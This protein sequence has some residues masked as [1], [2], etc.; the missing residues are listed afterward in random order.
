ML[1]VIDNYS[2]FPE[3]EI[4]RSTAAE[5]VIQKFDA[6]LARHGLPEEV[7]SDNGSP[8]NSQE[9]EDYSKKKGFYHHGVTPEAPWANGYAERFMQMIG[10]VIQTS[11]AERKN[12]R[13][14]I[15]DYLMAYRAT[16]HAI[17]GKSPAEMLFNRPIRTGLPQLVPRPVTDEVIRQ[18]E[19]RL[20]SKA[21]EWHDQKHRVQHQGIK[22]GDEL[23]L[24]N[25]TQGKRDPAYHPK[26]FTAKK[27]KHSQ[28]VIENE[29]Q[30]LVRDS[31]RL[32]KI[33][34]TCRATTARSGEGAENSGTG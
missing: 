9:W 2:R 15:H 23:L 10:K 28:I 24:Q 4:V 25:T 34:K 16:P 26:P 11:E 33:P 32:K 21:K 20:K 12:P 27:V 30:R 19:A 31:S 5:T 7:I 17:T 3:I 29:E 8:F 6:I 13:A 1:L 22:V 18:R 14:T